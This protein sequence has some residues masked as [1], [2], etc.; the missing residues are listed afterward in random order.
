MPLYTARNVRD[1]DMRDAP[2]HDGGPTRTLTFSAGDA[3]LARRALATFLWQRGGLSAA[4]LV[5]HWT[6]TP[7]E[8][9]YGPNR[10]PQRPDSEAYRTDHLSGEA[11]VA[12]ETVVTF[13]REKLG[14][15]LRSDGVPVFWTP[16]AWNTEAIGVRKLPGYVVTEED[17]ILVLAHPASV[18]RWGTS[19]PT[20]DLSFLR[21]EYR[22]EEVHA[23]EDA[24]EAAGFHLESD[25]GCTVVFT[26]TDRSDDDAD[27]GTTD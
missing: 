9:A 7:A 26:K 24:L 11:L 25:I 2:I 20:G 23:L 21:E 19:D 10:T 17:A 6:L 27:N 22:D 3:D 16:A 12:A 14:R 4:R 1:A 13:L 18:A 15:A 5:A 8:S